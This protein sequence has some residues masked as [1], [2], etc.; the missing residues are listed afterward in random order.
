MKKVVARAL[1][2]LGAGVLAG[3][4]ALALTCRNCPVALPRVPEQ[5]EAAAQAFGEGLAQGDLAAVSSLIE[6]NP[7]LDPAP[8]DPVLALAWEHYARS[9]SLEFFGNWYATNSGICRDA[10]VTA[11]DIPAALAL[12]GE[13]YLE[14]LTTRVNESVLEDIRGEDGSYDPDFVFGVLAEAL[15]QVLEESPCTLQRQLSLT[16][17]FREGR[18][19]VRPDAGLQNVFSGCMAGEGG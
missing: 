19:L 18:W 8:E 13:R 17:V 12:A 4:A 15:G 14:L 1:T 11:L 10:I 3:A 7:E 6:G 9:L 5:V 2:I 16:F